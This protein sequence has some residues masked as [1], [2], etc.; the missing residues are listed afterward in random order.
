MHAAK[1]VSMP[2]GAQCL[3][4]KQQDASAWEANQGQLLL[5]SCAAPKRSKL[6][7]GHQTIYLL[8][9]EL[10]QLWVAEL[11]G[12]LLFHV[13]SWAAATEGS[14]APQS[15]V[16]YQACSA[17]DRKTRIQHVVTEG[18]SRTWVPKDLFTCYSGC[19]SHHGHTFRAGNRIPNHPYM[20]L[21]KPVCCV[22]HLAIGC[23]LLP[24]TPAPCIV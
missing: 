11:A 24:T 13:V 8:G 9:I 19:N 10:L 12:L 16:R 17:C 21:Q 5:T 23:N 3:Q 6:Q 14:H 2:A 4:S 18:R 1:L 7:K 20:V 22:S 15:D